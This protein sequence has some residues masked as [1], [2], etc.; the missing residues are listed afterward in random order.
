M[1]VKFAA[2]LFGASLT[3]LASA[4]PALAQTP[5]PPP[6]QTTESG[7]TSYP[8]A[9]FADSQASNAQEVLQ[10]VPGFTLDGGDSGVRGFAGA[11]GNVLIDGERP[12]AKSVS[13]QDILRRIPVSAIDRIELIRAGDPTIDLQGQ[14]LVANVVRREGST[15][16][17]AISLVGKRYSDG[18]IGPRFTIEGSREVGDWEVEG[19]IRG[20]YDIDPESGS[21]RLVTTMPSGAVLRD[22]PL[23]AR[24]RGN[25]LSANAGASLRRAV[26]VI[27]LNVG[28][29]YSKERGVELTNRQRGEEMREDRGVEFGGDYERT[30]S[31]ILSAKVVALQTLGKVLNNER[32]IDPGGI[33]AADQIEK[34]GESILRGSLTWRP[35][36]ILSFEGGAEG[37]FNFLESNIAVTEN[38]VRIPIPNDNVR[39]EE[40]RAE[41]F[42]TSSWTVSDQLSAEGALRVE[43]SKISQSGDAKLSRN[44]FFAK[45]RLALSYNPDGL[46]NIRLRLEREVGQLNFGDFAASSD[47]ALGSVSAGNAKLEPE[48]AWVA[49][50]ALERRFWG[51]GAVV[52]TLTHEWVQQ[53]VDRLPI[54][55]LF[56]GPGNIGD[57]TRDQAKLTIALPL[58]RLGLAGGRIAGEGFLR[59]SEV[60]DPVT[61]EKRRISNEGPYGGAFIFSHDLPSI[62][63]TW[64]LELDLGSKRTSYRID[65]V[66]RE[67][68]E[69]NW[70]AYWEWKPRSDI[71][72]KVQVDNLT[73]RAF[74]RK[75]LLYDGPR[76]R[77]PV[78]AI[79]RR[80]VALDPFFFVR[81]RKQY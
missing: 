49:E 26:D 65:E 59:R 56:D 4:L 70:T 80:S 36:A 46:T 75:R 19:S 1:Y 13:L 29:E 32:S 71:A 61:G 7:R 43:V 74:D 33:E 58:D 34:S 69:P 16:S 47:L 60:T 15:A 24:E 23:F 18:W 64:G 68:V 17:L 35:S 73:S 39:I 77:F 10:R 45:P 76:S 38:G 42:V 78:E 53:V 52:L 8:I 9:F 44:F 67:T 48:R 81:V 66:R 55:A 11:G 31:S 54:T 63:S 40:R 20:F 27:R 51:E 30:L 12:A 5:E 41:G 37:A 62:A 3:T 2:L 25:D 14:S 50:A 28:G 72:V 6:P 57:G 79:E 21:G 22:S